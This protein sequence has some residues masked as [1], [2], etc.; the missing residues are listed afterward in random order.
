M[1][2]EEIRDYDNAIEMYTKTSQLYEMEKL[3]QEGNKYN[4]KICELLIK[5]EKFSELE[6]C[7]KIYEKVGKK[8][9]QTHLVKSLAA[10]Y[11]YLSILCYIANDDKIGAKK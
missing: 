9:L 5:Q 6:R 4:L 11:F 2:L 10:N 8:S 1:F 3:Y 7:A